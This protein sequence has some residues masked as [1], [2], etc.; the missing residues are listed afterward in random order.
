MLYPLVPEQYEENTWKG[1]LRITLSDVVE[2]SESAEIKAWLRAKSP[3]ME[4]EPDVGDMRAAQILKPDAL[5]NNENTRTAATEIPTRVLCSGPLTK[6]IKVSFMKKVHA[7]RFVTLS[8]QMLPSGSVYLL[9][10][11]TEDFESFYEKKIIG[12]QLKSH[13]VTFEL[14]TGESVSYL[15]DRWNEDDWAPHIRSIKGSTTAQRERSSS[16]AQLRTSLQNLM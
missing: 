2:E 7:S 13:I 4:V 12:C 5:V 16:V 9:R 3:A 11:S 8:F 15:L 10:E 1:R 14:E 6:Y